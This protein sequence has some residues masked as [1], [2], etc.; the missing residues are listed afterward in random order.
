M[1]F[2]TKTVEDFKPLTVLAKHVILDIW[3][4]CEY[5]STIHFCF[6]SL[7]KYHIVKKVASVIFSYVDWKFVVLVSKIDF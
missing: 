2:F 6:I 5:V 1:E 4:G 3:Q 7:V